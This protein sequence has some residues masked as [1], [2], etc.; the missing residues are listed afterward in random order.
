MA[1]LKP[2]PFCGG[3]VQLTQFGNELTKKRGFYVRCRECAV[4][5]RQEAVRYTLDWLRPKVVE[6]WN[7]RA[8]PASEEILRR[9]VAAVDA[10][11]AR[12]ATP[13]HEKELDDALDA[14][15]EVLQ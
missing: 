10:T 7:R 2:C 1:D 8:L 13:T 12:N 6:K 3:E 15:R 4:E 11:R 9:L 14:A 5:L